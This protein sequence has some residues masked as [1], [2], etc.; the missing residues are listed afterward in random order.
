MN[1][2]TITTGEVRLSYVHL[3]QPQ[4][5]TQPGAEPKY[6]CTVLIPKS[7]TATKAA[8]DAAIN[9]AIEDGV[10]SKWKGV[11]PP[12]MRINVYDGDGGRPSDGMPYGAECK[13]HWVLTA[14][15]KNRPQIVD[16]SLQEILDGTKVYSGVYAR[17]NVSFFAYDNSGNKGIGCGLN[18]VQIMR[19]GDAL[20]GTV[21]AA[22]AFGSPEAVPAVNPITGAPW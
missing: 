10:Q 2:N 1:A 18:C 17:V 4:P 21:S 7:D 3:L 5:A 22:E 13:G 8:I 14:R 11:R 15:C 20:G 6:S 12:R 19:D 9:A 16:T